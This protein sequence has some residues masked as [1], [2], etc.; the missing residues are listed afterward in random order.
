M[1]VTA[2]ARVNA[3]L[4]AALFGA[5][6]PAFAQGY[7]VR[8]GANVSPAQVYG[9]AQYALAPVWENL[10]PTPSVDVAFG[11]GT[12]LIALN[13]DLLLH[14]RALGRR[15]VWTALVGG[16]PSINHHRLPLNTQTGV[17]MNAV[18]ALS[19]ASGWF[20]EFRLGFLK[21]PDVRFG[22][23]YQWASRSRPRKP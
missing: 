3:T 11:H 19:H 2:L 14:S 23:G 6:I 8:G 4:A 21:S 22:V 15:S 17:G 10:R 5:A 12:R 7:A 13:M 16:G 1:H 9:G 18:A 20:S